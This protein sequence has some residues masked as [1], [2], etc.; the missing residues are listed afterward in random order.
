[1]E[2]NIENLGKRLGDVNKLPDFLKKQIRESQ[3]DGIEDQIFSVLKG[4]L[5][6]QAT[7]SEIMVSLYYKYNVAD[8]TRDD[9]TKSIYKIMRRGLVL[10]TKGKKGI[11][12]INCK[13]DLTQGE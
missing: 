10:K 12:E 4:D 11:Y 2:K 7:L 3:L 5:E 9:I 13:K 8:K 6:G 1:M